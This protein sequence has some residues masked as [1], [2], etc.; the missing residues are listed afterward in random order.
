MHIAYS[1]LKKTYCEVWETEPSALMETCKSKFRGDYSLYHGVMRYWQMASGNYE[2]R[3]RKFSKMFD[4]CGMG[5]EKGA[6]QCIR[7]GK[8]TMICINDNIED[9]EEF[10][11]ISACVNSAFKERFP[12]KSEFEI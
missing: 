12:D 11:R 3:P 1:F 9:D 4:I 10:K 2:I 7:V 8:P 5:D 6:I